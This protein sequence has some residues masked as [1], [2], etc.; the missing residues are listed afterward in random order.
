[1]LAMSSNA[2]TL[3]GLMLCLG[4]VIHMQHGLL[5]R[6]SIRAEP[7]PVV[8]RGRPVTVLCQGPAGADIFRV[9]KNEHRSTYTD[10]KITSQQGSPGTEARFPIRAE[11]PVKSLPCPQKWAPR[12]PLLPRITWRGTVSISA[13]PVWS[14]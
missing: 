10:H 2:T 7:G 11:A 3:L 14:C 8:P 1:M 5:P 12:Q 13:W 6:P 9:E 4:Q